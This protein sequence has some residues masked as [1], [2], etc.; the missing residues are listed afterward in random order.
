MKLL[1]L[2]FI[3]TNITSVNLCADISNIK[4]LS[5]KEKKQRF[6]KI[7]LPIVEKIHNELMGKY[8]NIERNI[9][10]SKELYK[11]E[12]LMQEYKVDCEK[13]LLIAL[14]PHPK[15]ITLAQAA[16][17]SAWAT[18][19]FFI[20]ANNVFGMWSSNKNEPRIA[21][22]QKRG[23]STIWLKKFDSIEDSIRAY[24]KLLATKKAYKE[25]RELRMRTDD[26]FLLAS[27]LN[28]YCELGSEYCSSIQSVIIYNK[29]AKYD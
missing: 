18:S 1:L 6:I 24:Y 3:L 20:E 11:T 10:E 22:L 19:R 2:L 12:L 26:V 13:E 15:S 8:T 4:H 23:N 5:T 28:N 25:F 17:E 27:K 21:A 7:I 29:F 9:K 14:K 16:I